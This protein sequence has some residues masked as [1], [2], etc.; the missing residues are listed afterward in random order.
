M[1]LMKDI[2]YDNNKKIRS[3]SKQVHL[4]LSDEDKQLLDEMHEFLVISQ[5]EERNK[6][7]NLRPGVGLAAI[8]VGVPKRMIAIH[9]PEYDEEGK[10]VASTDLELVNPKI[11]SYTKKQ[12]YLKNGEGCL[13]VDREVKGL[14]PR[15][16]KITVQAYEAISGEKIEMVARGFIAICLQHEIDHLDGIL[17]YDHISKDYPMMP[18]EGAMEIE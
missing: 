9:I 11:V 7:F 6:E 3:K 16:A 5:D 2:V 10:V 17:F 4:P 12:S 13:S 15:H 18:I 1:L 8:Q 14:V